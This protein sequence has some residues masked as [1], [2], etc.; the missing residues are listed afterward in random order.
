MFIAP[1]CP[2]CMTLSK[3]YNELV[4]KYPEIQFLAVHSGKNYEAMEINMFA[5]ETKFKPYIFR[6]YDYAIAHKLNATI[7]PEFVLLD[8]SSTILYQGLMDDRILKLGSYKQ[9][10]TNHYL[11]D[12]IQAVLSKKKVPLKKTEPVGCVLEY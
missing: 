4:E 9:Q 3:S 11:D 12:A 2:L 1:D 7:T 5:T 10:W 8:S 6:D